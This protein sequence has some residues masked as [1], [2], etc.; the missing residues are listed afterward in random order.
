MLNTIKGMLE[1]FNYITSVS[2]KHIG[3][4][5]K[6]ILLIVVVVIIFILLNLFRFIWVLCVTII[7]CWMAGWLL[8]RVICVIVGDS[9]NTKEKNDKPQYQQQNK[10]GNKEKKMG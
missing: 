9:N 5:I 3:Y 4:I 6:G 8:E 10:E 2:N 7:F 1:E